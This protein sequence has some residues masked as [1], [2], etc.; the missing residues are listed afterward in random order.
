MSSLF[1]K[2]HSISVSVNKKIK[3][4]NFVQELA[5]RKSRHYL[6]ARYTMIEMHHHQCNSKDV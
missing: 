4:C 3:S 6:H 2:I 1:Y 5:M